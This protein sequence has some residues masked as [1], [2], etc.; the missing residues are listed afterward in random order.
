M[1][2]ERT[3]IGLGANARRAE[4]DGGSRCHGPAPPALRTTVPPHTHPRTPHPPPIPARSVPRPPP[5]ELDRRARDVEHHQRERRGRRHRGGRGRRQLWRHL[6]RDDGG[7]PRARPLE[8]HG[9]PCRASYRGRSGTPRGPGLGGVA[10]CAVVLR[11]AAPLGRAGGAGAGAAGAPAGA[12]VVRLRP[13]PSPAAHAPR[14]RP[15]PTTRAAYDPPNPPSQHAHT[16]HAPTCRRATAMLTR[17]CT[18]TASP[19]RWAWPPAGA[20]AVSCRGTARRGA[21]PGRGAQAGRGC[22]VRHGP[23]PAMGSSHATGRRTGEAVGACVVWRCCAVREAGAARA[24]CAVL[25]HLAPSRPW[26]PRAPVR[27]SHAAVHAPTCAGG[28][29]RPGMTSEE[30][31]V[32]REVGK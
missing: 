15:L 11:P 3:Q 19:M 22:G 17:Q 28:G 13:P 6:P 12:P 7:G 25:A 10:P 26:R 24:T 8:G 16:P 21:G 9:T 4:G 2:R 32:M 30:S 31:L 20:A 1:C 27:C 29:R 18:P 14:G 23:P 5:V